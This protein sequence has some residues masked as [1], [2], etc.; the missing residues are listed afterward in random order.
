MDIHNLAVHFLCVNPLCVYPYC[1][2]SETDFCQKVFSLHSIYVQPG[3]VSELEFNV[4]FQ[5]KHGYIRDER[6][7]MES[8]PYPV[9]EG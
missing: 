1:L 8:Y 2:R 4:P 7:G 9:K 6:P 5:H 3:D